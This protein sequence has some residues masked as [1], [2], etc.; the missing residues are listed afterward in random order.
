MVTLLPSSATRSITI[1]PLDVSTSLTISAPSSAKKGGSFV[2]SGILIRNDTSGPVTGASITL[3][4]NGTSLGSATTGVDGDYLKT[5]SIGSEGTFTLKA[6]FA[7]GSG[8]AASTAQSV[9]RVV[10]LAIATP[11]IIM[12][13]QLVTGLL[14]I[15]SGK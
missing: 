4:Y 3:S 1:Q 11:I 12:V 6:N 7:G 5:V 8:Y 14:L 15:R 10:A 2:I 9:V 13:T